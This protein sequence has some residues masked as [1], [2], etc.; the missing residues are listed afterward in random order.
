LHEKGFGKDKVGR[1]RER[2]SRGIFEGM[3]RQGEDNRSL[4]T[5]GSAGSISERLRRRVS[6]RR[7]GGKANLRMGRSKFQ[8][9]NWTGD[10]GIRGFEKGVCWCRRPSH[11]PGVSASAKVT[12]KT[13][14]RP[15]NGFSAG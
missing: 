9:Y 7:R 5:R 15:W 3:A 4:R 8:A 2:E 1:E 6:G 12:N 14:K 10:K 13:E 11:K